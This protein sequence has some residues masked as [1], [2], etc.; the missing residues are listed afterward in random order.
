MF[1]HFHD[2][3]HLP[4]QGSLSKKD[5][6]KMISWLSIN[7]NLLN[8]DEYI[9]KFQNDKLDFNDIC[10]SFD[11]GL[12]CQFDIAVPILKKYEIKAFFFI[13]SSTFSGI[14][15]FL[16]IFRFFRTTFKGGTSKFYEIFFS[17]IKDKNK[18]GYIEHFN[19][20]KSLDYLKIFPFYSF[21][22]KWFRYIRDEFLGPKNYTEVMLT[23]MRKYNFDYS[24]IGKKL[25]MSQDQIRILNS[26]NH[27]IGLHSHS[28][29]TQM[30]RLSREKQKKEY[31][32]NL[33]SLERI[34]GK[35]TIISMSHPCGSYNDETL[36]ILQDLNIKIGFR[37][38]LS[39]KSIKS[40]LEIP[41]NDHANV[42]LEMKNEDYVI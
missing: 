33:I 10:L 17:F 18:E 23:L 35:N 29:P 21:E 34:L 40:S 24:E 32:N 5:F 7:Y 30:S 36:K 11:D 26:D 37:S 31:K 42:F 22:D 27:I 25:W 15:D 4:A 12:L 28:H 20:F 16:E 2:E 38:N 13:Y 41:R 6:E 3:N 8:A 1:H 19:H 9:N 39:I 14:P